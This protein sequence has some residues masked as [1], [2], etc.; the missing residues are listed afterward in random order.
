M[1]SSKQQ[2]KKGLESVP[3]N[4]SWSFILLFRGSAIQAAASRRNSHH[5]SDVRVL[6]SFDS[7]TL[8]NGESSKDPVT[9]GVAYQN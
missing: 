8:L 5:H 3:T 9:C 2:D 4:H 1:T 7:A 6:W